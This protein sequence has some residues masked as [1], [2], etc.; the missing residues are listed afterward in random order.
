[1]NQRRQPLVLL[2]AILV[3]GLITGS[4]AQEPKYG[5]SITVAVTDDPPNLDPHI[6][7]AASA[8]NVLHNVFATI[9]EM[10]LDFV[11]GPGLAE[12][13]DISDDGL[14]YT[15]YLGRNR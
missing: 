13:W 3:F 9:V 4:F 1:M 14:T 5:G 10:N 8:R 15:F 6:T 12:S 11:P 7:N 2:A